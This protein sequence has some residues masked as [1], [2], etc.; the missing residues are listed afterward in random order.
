MWT[1]SCANH[2]TQPW[3][4]TVC[5]SL[6]ALSALQGLQEL[7]VGANQL[8]S[9]HGIQCLASLTML[10]ASNNRLEHLPSLAGERGVCAVH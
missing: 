10:N 9:L 3:P 4:V 5:C 8:T 6:E 2:V 1:P 7:R